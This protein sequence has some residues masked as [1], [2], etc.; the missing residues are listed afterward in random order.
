VRSEESLDGWGGLAGVC[1]PGV[2]R[3]L[4]LVV[5]LILA[6]ASGGAAAGAR[7]SSASSS[8]EA[9]TGESRFCQEAAVFGKGAN[10]TTLPPK[11]LAADYAQFKALQ[12]A[13]LSSA[14][15]AIK[16]DLQQIFTF[17]HELLA[18]L[19]KV[20]WIMAKL[21]RAY[22]ESFAIAGPKLKPA[23]DKVIGYLDS[24]CGLKLSTP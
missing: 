7:A 14:P 15:S 21:P 17:D 4:P 3:L 9:A 19:S 1:W 8:R 13:M 6:I 18:E 2:Q 10:L 16:G 24:T 20:G 5:L 12:P 11:T 22:L 23:S